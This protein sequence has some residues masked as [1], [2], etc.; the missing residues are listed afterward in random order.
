MER[1][2]KGL[3]PL[4]SIAS[5]SLSNNNL[6][7]WQSIDN[8]AEWL[9]SLQSL[10]IAGNPLVEGMG[11]SN[12]PFPRVNPDILVAGYKSFARLITA[13]LPQLSKLNGTQVNQTGRSYGAIHSY[14]L[15]G[16][17]Q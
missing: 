10:H 3:P 1:I 2:P 5:L 7:S 6:D 12:Y 15:Q 14:F 8:L 9:P 11:H 17:A 16:Y 4:S 13:R